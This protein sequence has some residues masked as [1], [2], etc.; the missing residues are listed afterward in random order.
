MRCHA[1][2]DV[3]ACAVVACS[4]NAED[5]M[6]A[7]DGPG[8]VA[9]P[10]NAIMLGI[11]H[12][13]QTICASTPAHAAVSVTPRPHFCCSNRQ[14]DHA[15]DCWVI[16]CSTAP[17]GASCNAVMHQRSPHLCALMRVPFCCCEPRKPI[18]QQLCPC[19]RSK[20]CMPATSPTVVLLYPTHPTTTKHDAHA[21]DSF[22]PH[23]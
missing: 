12:T 13:V 9:A 3:A 2:S 20:S 6:N 1:Q 14:P 8:I 7:C 15:S 23:N 5:I 10:K 11:M 16:Q 17:P 22:Q 21:K 18:R 4:S 19:M